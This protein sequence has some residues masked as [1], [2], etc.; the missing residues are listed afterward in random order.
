[1][2]MK[3]FIGVLVVFLFHSGLGA[4]IPRNLTECKLEYNTNVGQLVASEG[5]STVSS[6]LRL[7][8]NDLDLNG[9][10]LVSASEIV[11]KLESENLLN[12]GE[13]SFVLSQLQTWVDF[14]SQDGD[15]ELNLNEFTNLVDSTVGQVSAQPGAN[16][17]EAES[18]MCRY[19]N[20]KMTMLIRSYMDISKCVSNL[21]SEQLSLM[22]SGTKR[23]IVNVWEAAF[24]TL[25]RNSDGVVDQLEMQGAFDFYRKS[26]ENLTAALDATMRNDSYT[27]TEFFSKIH[28]LMFGSSS[29][30]IWGDITTM[31]Q[32]FGD[33]I[34][35]YVLRYARNDV[36]DWVTKNLK[37]SNLYKETLDQTLGKDSSVAPGYIFAIADVNKDG[38]VTSQEMKTLVEQARGTTGFDLIKLLSNE[39]VT[40]LVL[41][42]MTRLLPDH[43]VKVRVHPKDDFE[44]SALSSPQQKSWHAFCLTT[45]EALRQFPTTLN[46][47]QATPVKV[48]TT[49]STVIDDCYKIIKEELEKPDLKITPKLREIFNKLQKAITNEIPSST[50]STITS[51]S[52]TTESVSA[53]TSP[54]TVNSSPTT[55]QLQNMTSSNTTSQN[56]SANNEASNMTSSAPD[57]ADVVRDVIKDLSK[58]NASVSGEAINKELQML[59]VT[60][61]TDNKKEE[62]LS[63]QDVSVSWKP[64]NKELQILN[65]FKNPD[66]KKEEKTVLSEE[67]KQL[68]DLLTDYHSQVHGKTNQVKNTI[69]NTDLRNMTQEEKE[70]QDLLKDVIGDKN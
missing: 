60:E 27:E 12:D 53:T 1:M 44:L 20:K 22:A 19:I 41:S 24:R 35:C 68:L 32:L 23:I 65:V 21:K 5:V 43:V 64:I 14:G 38:I 57:L 37:C 4:A 39:G 15:S 7:F 36:L 42:N 40:S 25:D 54:T 2:I 62:D 3:N 66:N 49:P 45:I 8:F 56:D 58:Q 46:P 50:S 16:M 52:T 17:K 34:I 63:K 55:T 29:D 61:N 48:N 59:N 10:N 30:G 11:I 6:I 18:C 31:N 67:E 51:Q 28:D 9:N 69:M 26:N 47:V 13:M 70:L 33:C